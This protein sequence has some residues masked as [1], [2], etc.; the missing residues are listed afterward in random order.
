VHVRLGGIVRRLK[1]DAGQGPSSATAS[2]ASL[3]GRVDLLERDKLILNAVYGKGLGRYLLGIRPN[4]GAF[5]DA[6]SNDLE[7]RTNTGV[8]LAYQ[9][10]W[11]A[12]LRSTLMGGIARARVPATLAG[13]AFKS[14]RYVSLNLMKRLQPYLTVGIEY[15]YGKNE[16]SASPGFDNHRIAVGVQLF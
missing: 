3:T 9:H 8:M 1:A 11:T 16:F 2:G 6:A 12:D 13:D 5:I 14:S 7:L 10:F 4:A 15:A